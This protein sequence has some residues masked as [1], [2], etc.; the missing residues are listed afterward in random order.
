HGQTVHGLQFVNPAS[1]SSPTLYYGAQSSGVG[2]AIQSLPQRG[3]RIGLVG[4][5]VG[6]LAAYCR[7]NDYLR[8]YEINLDVMRMATKYFTYASHCPASAE[9]VIGDARLCLEKEPPQRF[10]LLAMDAFNGDSVPVHL[11][12]K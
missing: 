10:D 1:A 9:C 6:T 7:T 3:R 11:L 12:T 8:A 4:L 5:G 2:L